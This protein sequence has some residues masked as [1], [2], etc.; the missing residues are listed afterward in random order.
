MV[1]GLQQLLEV[2]H[3]IAVFTSAKHRRR[4]RHGELDLI[5]H[6]PTPDLPA[7]GAGS[8]KR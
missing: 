8:P 4:I 2:P 3:P 6:R 7:G 1:C 5:G